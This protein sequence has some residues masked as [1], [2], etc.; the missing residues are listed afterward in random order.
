MTLN[1]IV[2]ETCDSCSRFINIGQAITECDKCMLVIHTKCFAKSGFESRDDSFYCQIC[3]HNIGEQ[4]YNPFKTMLNEDDESDLFYNNDMNQYTGE[5]SEASSILDACTHLCAKQVSKLLEEK[6]NNCNIY[7]HNID[8]N[9]TNFDTLATEITKYKN[10]FSAIGIAETNIDKDHAILYP[11]ENY[12]SFYNEKNKEKAKGTGVCL[13]IHNTFTVTINAESTLTT[14][15]L[16]ALFTCA[17]KGKTTMNIGVIYHPPNS[18]FTQFITE[19]ESVINKLP[20]RP[21]HIMGDF[22]TDMLKSTSNA[23]RLEEVLISAGLFPLI[24]IATHNRQSD[25]HVPSCIDNI[26]TNRVEKVHNTGI[27]EDYG[28]SHSPIYALL[29]Y[30]FTQTG[31]TKTKTTQYY[32]YSKENQESLLNFLYENHYN[33]IS[34][35]ADSNNPNFNDFCKTVQEGID[36]TCKLDVPKTTT[37]N[38]INNPWITDGLLESIQNK[39]RL[40]QTWRKSCSKKNPRGDRNL[41]FKFS[42]YR[43]CFNHIINQA[44]SMHYEKKFTEALHNPKRTWD[45]LNEIRGKRKRAI[46][47]K[48]IIDNKKITDRRIIATEFNKYYVSLATK[49]NDSVKIEPL[50]PFSFKDFLPQRTSSSMFLFETT[51]DEVADII[52]Q[53]QNGKASDIPVSVIKKI[54]P[55]ISPIL[56]YHYNHLM[57]IGEFPDILK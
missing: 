8:G 12:N 36:I 33:L 31:N 41:Y 15:H 50:P 3:L 11:L 47:P 2:K 57:K 40:Y 44:K 13:Y 28:T 53:F 4:R 5:L 34:N 9:K 35:D 45:V 14:P 48:F 54:S 49:L 55:A 51:E 21:T 20:K 10:K 24:S 1:N 17:T 37:R 16:E 38:A 22:N 39:E 6:S 42:A 25:K 19:L 32:S 18:D 46:K 29:D 26:Y 43:K 52:K 30:D 56:A 27:I 23:E 7:F